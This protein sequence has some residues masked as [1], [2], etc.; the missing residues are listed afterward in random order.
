MPIMEKPKN[1]KENLLDAMK[2]SS[3][4]RKKEEAAHK[5]NGR[6]LFIAVVVIIAIVAL[7]M[8]FSK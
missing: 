2:A 4:E 3:E 8:L 5:F 6:G 7:A 1:Y